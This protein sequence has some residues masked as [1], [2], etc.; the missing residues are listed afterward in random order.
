MARYFAWGAAAFL[1]LTGA[2][3]LWQGGAQESAALP[4]APQPRV[5]TPFTV[6]PPTLPEAPASTPKTREQKRFGRADKD[7][8]GRITAAELFDP[9]RKAFA[10]LDTNSNGT[11][12]FDEWAVKTVTKFASADKDRSG[13]LTPAEYATTAPPPPKKP[14]CGC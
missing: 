4:P 1:M 3:L 11:L 7:D 13:W 5:A 10:K 9:R 6:I 12:S 8:D 2:F 14:R